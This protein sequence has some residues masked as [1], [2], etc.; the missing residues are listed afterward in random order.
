MKTITT[1]L[2]GI[3]LGTGLL[4]GCG[5]GSSAQADYNYANLQHYPVDA[6]GVACYYYSN[7][8]GSL[9]CVKVVP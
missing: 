4:Y 8:P 1:L 3:L 9:S 7:V 6:L 2:A 5:S